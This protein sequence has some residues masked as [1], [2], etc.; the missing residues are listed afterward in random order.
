MG[1]LELTGDI[2]T[3]LVQ[4]VTIKNYERCTDD[5]SAIQ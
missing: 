1:H 5:L 2:F 3:I 4:Y